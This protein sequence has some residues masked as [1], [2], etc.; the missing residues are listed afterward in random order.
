VDVGLS[1][2]HWHAEP[3]KYV[4]VY[5]FIVIAPAG[6]RGPVGNR[7][8]RTT[9]PLRFRTKRKFLDTHIRHR[10]ACRRSA[11]PPR[12]NVVTVIQP[13]FLAAP[14]PRIGRATGARSARTTAARTIDLPAEVAAANEEHAPTQRA[15]NLK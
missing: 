14:V 12:A 8:G 15:T 2:S 1:K 11:P 6:D 9:R 7:R 13:S 10:C 3:A 5:S 4:T